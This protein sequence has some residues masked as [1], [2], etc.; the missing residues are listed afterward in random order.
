MFFVWVSPKN[1]MIVAE[2]VVPV[3]NNQAS[4]R[5]IWHANNATL[6]LRVGKIDHNLLEILYR[7]WCI[8]YD[9]Y[10]VKGGNIDTLFVKV[11][12]FVPYS[13]ICQ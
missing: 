8:V 3:I 5:A 4:L 6:C 7:I 13:A 11:P 10:V 1:K 12:L 2:K 9:L